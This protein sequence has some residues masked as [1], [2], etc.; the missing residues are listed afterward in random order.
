ML[1]ER[2]LCPALPEG[3]GSIQSQSGFS[4]QES[5]GLQVGVE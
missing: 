3:Q 1:E 2:W 5:K 4:S